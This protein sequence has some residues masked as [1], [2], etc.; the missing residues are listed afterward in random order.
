MGGF[1][2]PCSAAELM[3]VSR[4]QSLE[5][6]LSGNSNEGIGGSFRTKLRSVN[7]LAIE[8]RMLES[9]VGLACRR[10]AIK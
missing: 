7:R 5:A 1:S 10:W 3:V 4:R 2:I 9:V 8:D 6:L